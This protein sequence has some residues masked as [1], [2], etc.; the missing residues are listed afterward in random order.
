MVLGAGLCFL[1]QFPSWG[2]LLLGMLIALTLGNPFLSRTQKL[3]SQLLAIA[4]VGMGCGMN[5]QTVAET[6]MAGLGYTVTGITL[7]FVLGSLLGKVLKVE[8]D[9][10]LLITSGTAICGGSA[11][12][13]I[14]SAIRPKNQEVSIALATVFCLNALGLLIF[15]PVGHYL[16]LDQN[17]FGLWS[18]LAIHD[19]SSVVGSTL[20]FGET[21]LR[22]GTTVKLARALWIVPLTLLIGFA[23]SK[24]EPSGKLKKPWFILGFLLAATLMTYVPVLNPIGHWIEMVSK[25]LL[26]LT[27]FLIGANLTAQTLKSVGFKPFLMGVILWIIVASTVLFAILKG[28][29]N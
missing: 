9:T 14:A 12:A 10:S 19:T 21:A 16:N 29:I 11:I 6:G 13:A 17:Q 26:V 28:L 5:L 25:R 7:T 20:Q 15:P 3:T 18:A 2:A 24:Q 22:V 27:L 4:I 23:R 1:P 8:K